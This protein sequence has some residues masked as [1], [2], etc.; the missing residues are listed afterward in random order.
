MECLC[1]GELSWCRLSLSSK[2]VYVGKKSLEE[3]APIPGAASSRLLVVFRPTTDSADGV[4][5]AP[6]SASSGATTCRSFGAQRKLPE[7]GY[8]S[9]ESAPARLRVAVM[10]V[11]FLREREKFERIRG[12]R[13]PAIVGGRNRGADSLVCPFLPYRRRLRH[14]HRDPAHRPLAACFGADKTVCLTSARPGRR[15]LPPIRSRA[16][17]TPNGGA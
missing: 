1:L 9:L 5:G 7:H 10:G 13:L 14:R 6:P 16:G 3:A 2:A 17:C 8:T 15:A 4:A 12:R 11:P